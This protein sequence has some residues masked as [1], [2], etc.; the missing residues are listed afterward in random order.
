MRPCSTSST[1][2]ATAVPRV[3]EPPPPP[4]DPHARLEKEVRKLRKKIRE[5]DTLV[6]KQSKGEPLT[7]PEE[8]KLQKLVGW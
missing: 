6:D 1:A 2:S 8:D 5:C 3:A 7:G 4:E